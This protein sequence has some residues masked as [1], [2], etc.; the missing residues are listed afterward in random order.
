MLS[1]RE[2]KFVEYWEANRLREKKLSTQLLFGIPMGLIFALPIF[3]ILFTAK[4]WYT[5]ADMA[6]HS[7]NPFVLVF[8][9]AIIT[10]FI[11][12]FYKKHQ[13]DMK[14]QQYLELKR[15]EEKEQK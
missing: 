2:R 12:V 3:I 9:V 7:V 8:A 4:K 11:A 13:W 15:K 14:E 5:R 6:A 10:V 1:K